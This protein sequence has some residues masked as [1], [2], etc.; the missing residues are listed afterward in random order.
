[1]LKLLEDSLKPSKPTK[2]HPKTLWTYQLHYIAPFFLLLPNSTAPRPHRPAGQ[3]TNQRSPD[4]PCRPKSRASP[5]GGNPPTEETNTT[6]NITFLFCPWKT[7]RINSRKKTVWCFHWKT[8]R[9]RERCC[10]EYV[11]VCCSRRPFKRG[12]PNSGGCWKNT[13]KL[14]F[15]IEQ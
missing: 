10:T 9:K 6:V 11:Y 14:W 4:S 5:P 3:T 13:Q 1:M 12:T 2:N 8:Q 7:P 15:L